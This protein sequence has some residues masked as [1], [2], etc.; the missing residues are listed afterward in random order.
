MACPLNPTGRMKNSWS[1]PVLTSLF[2]IALA[3]CRGEPVPRDYQNNPPAMSHPVDSS[4][5]APNA[6]T[7]GTVVPEPSYGAEGT[8]APY[9]STAA[10]QTSTATTPVL[11]PNAETK[12][13]GPTK[14]VK[15]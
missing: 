14:K 8:S 11:P 15:P 9:T 5:E 3:G 7:T 13:E 10:A 12:N 4:A 1:V 6:Q 2:L